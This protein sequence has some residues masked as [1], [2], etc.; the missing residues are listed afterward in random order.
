MSRSFRTFCLL[1][2][3]MY[4]II[5][6]CL[7]RYSCVSF[8]KKSLMS[9]V[10]SPLYNRPR[11]VTLLATVLPKTP[12]VLI[13]HKVSLFRFIFLVPFSYHTRPDCSSP[14]VFNSYPHDPFDLRITR[15]RLSATF[16][17][18]MFSL[19]NRNDT[20][21]RLWNFPKFVTFPYP[22]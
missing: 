16:R 3:P 19:P 18:E 20:N 9:K 1:H 14:T 12:T 21:G 5:F 22:K 15:F 11:T 13:F 4:V 8:Y 2:N 17:Y 7:L 6:R 10:S